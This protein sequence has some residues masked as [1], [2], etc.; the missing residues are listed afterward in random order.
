[1]HALSLP[2]PKAMPLR[3]GVFPGNPNV[4][5]MD[6]STVP[7]APCMNIRR[8]SGEHAVTPFPLLVTEYN[9]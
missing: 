5:A 1:M 8:K 9:G 6:K 7:P 3:S 4:G 2:Y